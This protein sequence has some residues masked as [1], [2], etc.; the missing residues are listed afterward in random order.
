MTANA[1]PKGSSAKGA[2]DFM[3]AIDKIFE[4]PVIHASTYRTLRSHFVAV[5]DESLAAAK[6]EGTREAVERIRQTIW[7]KQFLVQGDG[8]VLGIDV[9]RSLESILDEEAAR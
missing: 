9:M 5:L 1:L 4:E 3:S 8:L 2:A 6:R 7:A